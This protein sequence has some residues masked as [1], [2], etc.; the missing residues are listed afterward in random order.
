MNST[1]KITMLPLAALCLLLLIG[2][3]SAATRTV[4]N[5]NDS[6]PGS[7]R[8]TIAASGSGDT[9]NFS[10][11]GTV[12]LTSGALVISKTLTINGPGPASFAIAGGTNFGVFNVS[13]GTHTGPVAS[14]SGLLIENG[15]SSGAGSGGVYNNHGRVTLTDCEIFNNSVGITNRGDG[16]NFAAMT[17]NNCTIVNNGDGILNYAGTSGDAELN[18]ANCTIYGGGNG[19][20]NTGDGYLSVILT[21]CTLAYAGQGAVL[22]NNIAGSGYHLTTGNTIFAAGSDAYGPKDNFGSGTFFVTSNGYN[23]FDHDPHFGTVNGTTTGNQ[24]EVDPLLDPN[25]PQY[26]GGP[27]RT[28]ALTFYGTTPSPAIDHGNSLGLIT[29][30]RGQP[31]AYDNPNVANGSGTDGA[32]IGAYEAPADPIQGGPDIFVTT[33]TDHND[34]ACGGFDCTLRE[35]INAVNGFAYHP[36]GGFYIYFADGV[37]GTITLSGDAFDELYVYKSMTIW[38]PGAR[39]L[40]I[41]GNGTH[42][43]FLFDSSVSA[44]VSGLTIRDG[45]YNPSSDT[46][47]ELHQGGAVF[48]LGQVSFTDCAFINNSVTGATNTFN[49]GAGGGGQGGAIYNRNSL[50]LSRCTFSGNSAVGAVGTASSPNVIGAGGTGG[51]GRGGAIFDN[52]GLLSIKNCTFNGNTATG[53]NGG[54][55]GGSF[56]SLG[57][58]GTGAAVYSVGGGSILGCTIST[59]AGTG[60]RGSGF[61]ARSGASNGG[62]FVPGN[63][64][65]NQVGNTIIAGNTAQN[66]NVAPDAEGPFSSLGF[67]LIGIGD[68]SS[69]WNSSNPD[70]VGTTAAPINPRLGSLQNNGGPTDTMIL[71]GGSPAIDQGKSFGLT[72]DQRGQPRPFNVPSIPNASGGD[73]SDIGA[74]ELHLVT[75]TN[76]V[77]Q[78][79]HGTAG[80]FNIKLPLTGK[81]GVECRKGGAAGI[82]KLVFTFP[83]PV[84]VGSVK[85]TPDPKVAA[86]TATLTS[87]V[88]S[89]AKVTV[90]LSGVSNAQTI[91]ITLSNVTDGT[92]T[93]NLTVP[94]GVLLGD[95]N[96]T[97]SVTPDDVTL[98]QSKV[99]Q[100]VTGTN[101]REDVTVDGSINSTDVNLVQSKVGTALP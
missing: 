1:I 77:S 45:R 30:Q 39:T 83:A 78:K 54:A 31:R 13:N 33:T 29:D 74:F 51:S 96:N 21:S 100:K 62:I 88:V 60:G 16:P 52:T 79:T 97:K 71:L 87:Y 44:F 47:G 4:T 12:S 15:G 14:I 22:Y 80:T 37:T 82:H 5:L 76:V 65:N 25:G 58:D 94:M 28:V 7:L 27:T 53:G 46:T 57:G 66:G 63:S 2:T 6:G 75:P 40:A 69:G 90:N 56:K 17:I 11:S 49:S 68:Q 93:N 18:L 36:F 95:T 85:V 101:F 70:E 98:T 35:A 61:Q 26:N 92:T 19:I 50:T 73:G 42:R 86:A 64:Q 67:N 41:S 91:R 99:G 9:I 3:T 89:G 20:N 10:V 48:S 55:S 8:D 84:T 38:G 81:A 32:D 34:G 72:T 23:L 59:N 43:I 24:Y